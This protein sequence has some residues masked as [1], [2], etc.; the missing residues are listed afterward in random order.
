MGVP[1]VVIALGRVG[2]ALLDGVLPLS[3]GQF[4]LSLAMVGVLLSLNRWIRLLANSGVAAIGEKVGAHTL[5]V[6]A[7]IGA[8][9]STTVYGLIRNA[10][11]PIPPP[12][13]WPPS[14][15]SPILTPLPP[16]LPPRSTPP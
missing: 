14:L 5:M 1:G 3:H 6:A 11:I 16:P 12:L 4:G 8:A 7:A 10:P 2:E 13:L 15:P 9:I